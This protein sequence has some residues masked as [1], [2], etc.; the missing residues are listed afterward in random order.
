MTTD[1]DNEIL[2]RGTAV[3]AT[4][5]DADGPT[6]VNG[7]AIGEDDITNGL[8]GKRTI[9]PAET[10]RPAAEKLVGKPIVRN[11]PEPEAPQPPIEAVIGEVTSARYEDGVGLLWQGELDDPDIARQVER[12]RADV[13][14]VLAREL[15]EFDDEADAHVATEIRAF[16][17]LGVVSSGAA[18]SNAIESGTAAAMEAEALAG[19]FDDDAGG[20]GSGGGDP[21]APADDD[22][23]DGASTRAGSNGGTMSD[24]DLTDKQK[25]LLA[26]AR[27]RD[28][29]VVVSAEDAEQLDDAEE[30][31][32]AADGLDSPLVVEETDYEEHQEWL[33]ALKDQM[34]DAL[35]EHEDYR[36]SEVLSMDFDEM[37]AEFEDDDGNFDAEAL[38]QN[39]ATGSPDDPDDDDGGL[40]LS[41]EEREEAEEI[42]GRLEY[43]DGKND[44]IVET[45]QEALTELVGADSFDDVDLEAI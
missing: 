33:G 34:A 25:E 43:W 42:L 14:P 29:P 26:Q 19:A 22:P 36:A 24:N 1:T 23:Q 30:L 9:W 20:D 16:R 7:V 31:L 15:G 28:D 17:D 10:L 37:M 27:Q 3:L 11:H 18:A 8:S 45:E 40:D 5:T 44:T 12:G 39:P 32:T 41:D 2:Q 35:V 4:D 13:S 38:V 21:D 6:L